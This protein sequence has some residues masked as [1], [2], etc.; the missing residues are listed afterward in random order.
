[1]KNTKTVLCLI[2]AVA[3]IFGCFAM[4]GC[5]NAPDAQLDAETEYKVSLKDYSGNAI[6]S[7]AVAVFYKDGE[8]VAM[9]V[10]GEDG[11]ATK[12]LETGDYT[13]E[14]QFTGG[15]AYYYH[16]EGLTV[17]DSA[18]EL[19]ITLYPKV[20]GS[21][22]TLGIPHTEVD[23]WG[24]N[25]TT[26]EDQDVYYLQEG[27]TYVD[28]T[29]EGKTYFVFV[30]TRGGV[31]EFSV[32]EG[33][34]CIF[35]YY[36]YPNY[37][38][39][40]P[41]QEIK[42][43]VCTVNL[44][45]SAVTGDAENTTMMVLA[46]TS[47]TSEH[48]VVRIAR[49]GD[50]EWNV[51]QEEWI[52]Y[53]NTTELEKCEISEDVELVDFDLTKSYE[54]VYNESD[55]YY[56]LGSADGKLIYAY[57]TSDPRFV[58]CFYTILEEGTVR[59]YFYDDDGNFLKKEAYGPCLKEYFDYTDDDWGVYPLTKELAYIIQSFGTKNGW[60]D[61]SSYG[62]IVNVENLNVDSAWLFMCCYEAE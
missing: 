23:E 5:Q 49:V 54:V 29:P 21:Q 6:G 40:E 58:D 22:I 12:K 11:V 48:C 1:M 35:G 50:P 41:V 16:N 28:V 26:T 39:E 10:C 38:R 13:V 43:G 32:I 19:E 4:S 47:E 9:Q 45:N 36:G 55:G 2:M 59:A 7:G 37:I 15:D 30:P 52:I 25:E 57:L 8:K 53:E 18:P 42:D 3:V 20:S 24:L 46:V 31:Y 14:L 44:D 51:S 61:A 60:W 62:Y 33:D 27:C 34:D 56:H 17:T